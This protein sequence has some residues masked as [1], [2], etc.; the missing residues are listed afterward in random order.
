MI[1][2]L[3]EPAQ[4]L[5]EPAPWFLSKEE[6]ETY[7]A[8]RFDKRRADWLLGRW[9]AKR[10]V[11]AFLLDI[12]APVIP[13]ETLV[14]ANDPYGVPRV[15]FTGAGTE[16]RA[17]PVISLSHS[18]GHALAAGAAGTL[19]LG[20]DLE[21]VDARTQTFVRDYFTGAEIERWDTTSPALR[22]TLVTAIWCAK[23]ATLKALHKGLSVDTRA[24]EC[25]IEPVAEAPECWTAFQIEAH[26]PNAPKLHGWWQCWGEFTLAIVTDTAEPPAA[27]PV[28][29]ELELV[30]RA[31]GSPHAPVH[32]RMGHAGHQ[33]TPHTG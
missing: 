14:I 25:L 10:L 11:Q 18:H 3:I 6:A 8:F 28:S 4:D 13:L 16:A 12:G 27:Q 29:P 7:A 19:A 15:E 17:L 2:W 22:D 32:H 20:C 21:Y 30:A 26:L 31:E 9:T 23:E 1:H 24:V 33:R 5:T